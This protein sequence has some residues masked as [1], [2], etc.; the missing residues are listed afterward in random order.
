MEVE[1]GVGGAGVVDLTSRSPGM[2]ASTR[3]L[4]ALVVVLAA[5]V[6]IS[7]FLMERMETPVDEA[8]L[9]APICRAVVEQQQRHY[10]QTGRYANA[11]ELKA[12]SGR[13]SASIAD[14]LPAGWRMDVQASATGFVFRVTP[15]KSANGD[16]VRR[17]AL[18]ADESGVIR[19]RYGR[20]EAGPDD[21][22]LQAGY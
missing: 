3:V 8:R 22:A 1:E 10:R 14:S 6:A 5:V 7:F 12:A 20:G 17:L 11:H 9:I 4:L 21:K 18:Y 15:V 16:R 2:K 19:M 13:G